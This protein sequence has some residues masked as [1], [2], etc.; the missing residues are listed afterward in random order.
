MW[1]DLG[2]L[3][4]RLWLLVALPITAMNVA[5]GPLVVTVPFLSLLLGAALSSPV[6]TPPQADTD[7]FGTWRARQDTAGG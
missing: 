4:P 5:V 1:Q 6:P 7:P 3:R 2:T